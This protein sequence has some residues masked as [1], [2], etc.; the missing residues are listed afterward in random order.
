MLFCGFC[1]PSPHFIFAGMTVF[2]LGAFCC[3]L[4]HF[5]FGDELLNANNAF[6]GGKVSDSAATSI[7]TSMALQ[8]SSIADARSDTSHLNLC[9]ISSANGSSFHNDGNIETLNWPLYC[10]RFCFM[11]VVGSC[12]VDWSI[13][14]VFVAC[15]EKILL[16]QEAHSQIRTAVLGIFFFSLLFI[17]IGQTAVSTLGIPYIDDNVA[18]KASAIYIGKH[19]ETDPGTTL[20]MI[21]FFEIEFDRFLSNHN[22]RADSRTIGWIYPRIVLYEIVRWSLRSWFRS[23]RSEMGRRMVSWWVSLLFLL[24]FFIDLFVMST[25]QWVSFRKQ[26][27]IGLSKCGEVHSL[28]IT[29]AQERPLFFSQ[30][31]PLCA[32]IFATKCVK[33][34]Q[35]KFSDSCVSV[36]SQWRPKTEFTFRP[37]E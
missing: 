18:S 1:V 31:I 23:K 6:Y 2:A 25:L 11:I 28:N 24:S 14:L 29:Y 19:I 21:I 5:I 8:N 35:I 37:N 22:W 12:H 36:I 3:T 16:E 27:N 33:F 32:G 30:T 26:P 34:T 4:P 17:G 20:T 7:S 9:R 13:S 10:F 15:E